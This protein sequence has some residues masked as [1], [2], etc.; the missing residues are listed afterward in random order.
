LNAAVSSVRWA[1]P[2][3]GGVALSSRNGLLG[4]LGAI[5]VRAGD[6]YMLGTSHVAG[7]SGESIWQPAPCGKD[8]CTC[9]RV[10]VVVASKR[11]IVDVD[12]HCYYV[13]CAAASIDTDVP[14]DLPRGG[15]ARAVRGLRVRKRGAVSGSTEGIVYDE[16]H[17]EHVV[18][19]TGHIAAPNQ[20][21]IRGVDGVPFSTTGDSG[22]LVTDEHGRAVGLLWGASAS[23]EAV[24]SHI[25]PVLHVLGLEAP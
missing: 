13:D 9:N 21:L 17:V 4:T 14:V 2:L 25:A 12:G 11:E 7:G 3:C 16:H 5:Y 10:G 8:G 22:A 19:A 6:P 20:I 24:A 1:R 23:G 15:K 18:L